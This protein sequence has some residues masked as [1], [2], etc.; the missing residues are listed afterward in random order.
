MKLEISTPLM[1]A[2]CNKLVKAVSTKDIIPSLKHFLFDATEKNIHIIAGDSA[3][4]L[5]KDIPCNTIKEVGKVSIDGKEFTR[6]INKINSETV[7]L[8]TTDDNKLRIKAGKSK[9]HLKTIDPAEYVY[10][11]D[12]QCDVEGLKI[13]LPELKRALKLGS[14]TVS[15][16]AT[17]VY[18]TG[19]KIGQGL[20]T[21][22]RNNMTIYDTKICVDDL[23]LTQDIVALLNDLD[24]DTAEIGYTA[25]FIE[26]KT[27]GT[28]I[29]GNLLCGLE[30]FPDYNILEQF[31]Y[32]KMALV[33]K[34]ELLPILDRA[35]IFV[36][37]LGAIE[38][39]FKEN[40]IECKLVGNTD[41]DTY[42]EIGYTGNLDVSIRVNVGMLSQIASSVDSDSLELY[43][44][45]S[46][47][48]LLIKSGPY[49][50][51]MASMA[52]E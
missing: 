29:L 45:T 21:T 14:I 8:E 46:E 38:L 33:A 51:L 43:V 22:N 40:V 23:L 20:M 7:V 28:R 17:E 49:K 34:K 19:Y 6:L 2:V 48:P 5:E 42:E 18:F 32:D 39:V 13:V 35:M 4:Y 10:P 47:S 24:G 36:E 27:E 12:L 1:Q 9:F 11:E 26:I 25:D 37:A 31:N 16:N 41:V 52:V 3:T 15:K 30:N 50:C 44:D